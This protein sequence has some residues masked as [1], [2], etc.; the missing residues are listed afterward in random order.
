[1]N[2]FRVR[3]ES[4]AVGLCRT[5]RHLSEVTSKN[6]GTVHIQCDSFLFDLARAGQIESCTGYASMNE[7]YLFPQEAWIMRKGDNGEWKFE[8]PNEA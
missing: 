8:N 6:K 5:C 1:M 7:S 4:G 3:A 2:R